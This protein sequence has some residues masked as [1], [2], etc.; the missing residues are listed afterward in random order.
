MGDDD[1]LY[2]DQADEVLRI[3]AEGKVD[4]INLIQAPFQVTQ[5]RGLHNLQHYARRYRYLFFQQSLITAVI[6]KTNL[7]TGSSIEL[8]YHQIASFFPHF[9]FTTEAIDRNGCIYFLDKPLVSRDEPDIN[10][11]GQLGGLNLVWYVRWCEACKIIKDPTIRSIAMTDGFLADATLEYILSQVLEFRLSG[12]PF[13]FHCYLRV[14]A[15]QPKY[16]MLACI[17]MSPIYFMPRPIVRLITWCAK[18]T[19]LFSSLSTM[20]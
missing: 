20:Y 14:L 7:I 3:C 17:L 9:A 11:L 8:A 13:N 5:P 19:N 18:K 2:I 6:T 1:I 16:L 15:V 12:N 4:L 10:T